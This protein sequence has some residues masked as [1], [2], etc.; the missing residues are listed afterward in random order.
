[1]EATWIKSDDH[2]WNL[3][4][5]RGSVLATLDRMRPDG[6]LARCETGGRTWTFKRVGFARPRVSIRAEGAEDDFAVL[7]PGSA[8]AGTVSFTGG[9]VSGW[10][11]KPSIGEWTW[12]RTGGDRVLTIRPHLVADRGLV[13]F[14]ASRAVPEQL[15]LAALG[16]YLI[17]MGAHDGVATMSA[18]ISAATNLTV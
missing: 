8:G 18:A 4:D 12:T 14:D 10:I 2:A 9:Q 15:R 1:M 5:D 3:V 11:S 16:W 6:T 13:S 17:L 7:H